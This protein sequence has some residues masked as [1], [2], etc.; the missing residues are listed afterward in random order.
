MANG[1]KDGPQTKRLGELLVE[2]GVIS[3]DNLNEAIKVQRATGKRIGEV[4]Q[5]LEMIVESQS[6]GTLR[7]YGDGGPTP[8]VPGSGTLPAPSITPATKCHSP[9][10][11]LTVDVATSAAS[12][13]PLS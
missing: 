9:T 5:D 7:V 2:E 13:I 11:L 12:K 3:L 6:G 1:K 10:P 8:V 4:L